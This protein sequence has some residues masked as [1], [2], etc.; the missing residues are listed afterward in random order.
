MKVVLVEPLG[1]AT[2]V[3]FER[4][5]WQVTARLPARTAGGERRDLALQQ[6]VEVYFHMEH[7]HLFDGITGMALSGSASSS[8]A[9]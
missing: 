6:N 4:D 2:L 9:G 3:T 7:G 5:G 8:P 1:H